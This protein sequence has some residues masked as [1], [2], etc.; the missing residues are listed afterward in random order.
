MEMNVEH[1][2]TS[3]EQFM[4]RYIF[5]QKLSQRWHRVLIQKNITSS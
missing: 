5:F 1:A 3:G 4:K 2:I